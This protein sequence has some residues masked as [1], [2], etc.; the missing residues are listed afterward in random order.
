MKKVIDREKE[1]EQIK[2]TQQLLQ[3]QWDKWQ[4][5]IR[6]KNKF[7]LTENQVN[8]MENMSP[9][10]KK[11]WIQSILWERYIEENIHF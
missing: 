10:E 8:A 1:A 7:A 2:L 9:K 5:K 11:K 3:E 6:E 4:L